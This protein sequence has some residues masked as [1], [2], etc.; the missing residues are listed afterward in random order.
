MVGAVHIWRDGQAQPLPA[1]HDLAEVLTAAG[2]R[3]DD[4][5]RHDGKWMHASA[6][7]PD[8][9]CAPPPATPLPWRL[10]LAMALALAAIGGALIIGW[11]S[12]DP[13]PAATP[14]PTPKAMPLP[15]V[16]PSDAPAAYEALPC[17]ASPAACA[18][19]AAH[20][21]WSIPACAAII[22]H[23]VT[24]GMRPAQVRESWGAPATT[25]ATRWCYAADCAKGVRWRADRVV[26]IFSP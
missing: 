6:V 4:L 25:D 3:A 17:A 26:E 15:A 22:K 16:P 1:G 5:I 23:Q 13:T 11:P 9:P 19:H 14:W 2:A 8:L 24:L 12:S 7:A 20:P 18:L 10:L 21:D